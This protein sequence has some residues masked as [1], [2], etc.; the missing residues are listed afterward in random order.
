MI[1]TVTVSTTTQ[2]S[3]LVS[4][5]L[6]EI[7]AGGVS[8]QDKNDLKELIEG[9]SEIFWDYIDEGLLSQDEVARVTGYFE[10]EPS[11]ERIDELKAMLESSRRYMTVDM[12]SLDVIV[13]QNKEDGDWYENWKSF[14]HPIEVGDITVVP[15]WQDVDA[16]IK[17]KIDPC[18]AFGTGE[19]ESTQM[20]LALMQTI[21]LADKQI[22]DVGCGSG[23]LGIAALKMGAAHCYF[24]D[25]D[26]NAMRNMRENAALNGVT[27]Y[28]A[29]TASLLQGCQYVADVMFANITA[30]ILM[31]LAPDVPEH[32]KEGGYIVLSGIIGEREQEVLDVYTQLGLKVVERKAIKDWRAYML[33]K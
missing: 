21:D 13:S 28:E 6:Y 30:D 8:I 5:F 17:V 20:C 29:R 9:K 23:I 12:G 31:L 14:Y 1:Y 24:A 22:V 25:I 19:H 7:G 10:V 33:Q 32:L 27:A 2:G 3:E 4:D 11:R 16:K 18:M 26:D 15:A